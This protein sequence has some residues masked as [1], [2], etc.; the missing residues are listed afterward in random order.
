MA[1]KSKTSKFKKTEGKLFSSQQ[2]T[3]KGGASSG[4]AVTP[5]GKRGRTPIGRRKK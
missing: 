4:K 1:K 3:P 2:K 5:I